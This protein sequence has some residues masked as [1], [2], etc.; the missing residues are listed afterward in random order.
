MTTGETS[1]AAPKQR[2][3]RYRLIQ[4]DSFRWL[5]RR[6]DGSIHA[7]V[8]DPPFGVVEY[9]SDQIEKR[10]NG[11]GGM[12]R[13]PQ[14]YDG[15]TRRPMPRFTSLTARHLQEIS[16]FSEKAGSRNISCS[17]A[18]QPRNDCHADAAVA[19]G[20]QRLHVM[21]ATQTLLSHLVIN[22]FILV[23][24]QL[25][26]QIA[27]TVST[28]RG[29][30]R[31]KF[32]HDEYPD[33]SVVPR[34]AWEPWLLFRKPL[35]GLVRDNL[36]KWK[37]GALRRPLSDVPF[38]DL[39]VSGPARGEERKIA[40]HPSLKPQAFMRQLVAAALPLEEGV[41]LDP[42]AGSGSTLAAAS[43]MGLE[44]I[45]IESHPDYYRMARRA[46]PKLA[47]LGVEDQPFQGAN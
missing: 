17:G 46:I 33:L 43:A 39:I 9:H 13:L 29:G 2:R 45:G 12:W 26:G 24:F 42:F 41:I 14:A 15:Y 16:R 23:G 40:D 8:T 6:A 32:A 22:A 27:R 47:A 30:D 18:W 5:T 36:K 20:D 10:N 34:S 28:L 19:L 35:D 38:R 11:A 7:V 1:I 4:G 37:T 44:S 31:P 3:G 21:I 25:R